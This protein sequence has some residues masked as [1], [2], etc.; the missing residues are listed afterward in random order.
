MRGRKIHAVS[1]ETSRRLHELLPGDPPV[2]ARESLKTRRQSGN[3]AGRRADGV[4][5]EL[6]AERDVEVDQLCVPRLFA[7]AGHSDETV[8]IANASGG[9][10]EIDRVATAEQSRHDRLGD[11]RRE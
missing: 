9:A 8:E 4:V 3:R 5:D 7:Q 11:A 6:G 1:S 2:L 10:L